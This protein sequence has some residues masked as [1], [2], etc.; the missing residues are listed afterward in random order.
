MQSLMLY[1][2]KIYHIPIQHKVCVYYSAF[3]ISFDRRARELVVVLLVL[4]VVLVVLKIVL[5]AALVL[6]VPRA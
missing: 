4:V 3:R 5:T 6:M 1:G 2:Y